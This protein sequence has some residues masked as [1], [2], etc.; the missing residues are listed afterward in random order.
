MGKDRRLL[1][2]LAAACCCV[3]VSL[4]NSTHAES[5]PTRYSM[6]HQRSCC[7][8]LLLLLLPFFLQQHKRKERIKLL[9]RKGFVKIAVETGL[10][11]GIIPVYHFG[12]TQVRSVVF[13]CTMP[14]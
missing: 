6:P 13:G 14:L 10:D 1:A 9:E 5:A 12:N 3:A 11:G 8:L 7:L 2:H 4:H